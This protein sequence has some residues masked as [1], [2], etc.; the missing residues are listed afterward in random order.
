MTGIEEVR[1]VDRGK[2]SKSVY[3]QDWVRRAFVFLA[4]AIWLQTAAAAQ[5]DSGRI[6]LHSTVLDEDREIEVHLAPEYGHAADVRYDV[7]YVL[8]AGEM[9]DFTLPES[10]ILHEH[11]LAP[12]LIVVGVHNKWLPMAGVNSRERDFQPTRA[13]GFPAS[14]GAEHFLAYLEKEL[15]PYIDAHYATT[16]HNI[17]FGHS[18]S[19]LFATYAML[20]GASFDGFVASDPALWWDKGVILKQAQA[21]LTNYSAKRKMFFLGGRAGNLYE[22]QGPSSLEQMLRAFAPRQLKWQARA[23]DDEQHG[24]VRAPILYDA[25]KFMYFGYFPNSV[26]YFPMN[27]ILL[28]GKPIDLLTFFTFLGYEPGIRYTTDGTEP[29]ETS[30]KFDYRTEIKGPANF[31]LRLFSTSGRFDTTNS[32]LFILG[33]QLSVQAELPSVV[34]GGLRYRLFRGSFRSFEDPTLNGT[35]DRQG[36]AD[37]R[38][39][40]YVERTHPFALLEDGYF[41]IDEDGYYT[42]VLS[43]DG[44]ARLSIDGLKLIDFDSEKDHNGV[45]SVILPL[46]SGLHSIAMEYIHRR[47]DTD[48]GLTFVP[49]TVPT[50]SR[51]F[52]IPIPIPDS[53]LYSRK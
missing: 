35:P 23:Y 13:E 53:S 17:L 45:P 36:T 27:G 28:P 9:L 38:L 43:C 18:F 51:L 47:G 2:P 7:L 3:G 46:S 29:T 14:G 42:F 10:S 41:K 25:L 19:G 15:I 1:S 44:V 22:A 34:P 11:G 37:R 30:P 24:S 40:I 52:E 49:S 48:F 12:S 32:G 8:D 33:K 5:A 50:S 26:S 6:V 21:S 4:C 39:D 20:K 16:G 31:H